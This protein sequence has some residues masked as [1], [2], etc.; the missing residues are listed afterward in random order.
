MRDYELINAI[1]VALYCAPRSKGAQYLAAHID[2][3]PTYIV[4]PFMV[5]PNNKP[6]SLL[7][8]W[9]VRIFGK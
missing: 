4:R 3:T 9:T 2:V 5:L 6:D 1:V 7:M 8:E